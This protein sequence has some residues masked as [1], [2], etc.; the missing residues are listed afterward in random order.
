MLKVIVD[1]RVNI[2][3]GNAY[4]TWTPTSLAHIVAELVLSLPILVG[5]QDVPAIV[6]CTF[7]DKTPDILPEAATA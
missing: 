2:I 1:S 6:V 7:P 3:P 4:L 5:C